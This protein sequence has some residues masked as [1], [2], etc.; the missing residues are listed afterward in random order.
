MQ[1]FK[2]NEYITLRLEDDHTVI[3]VVGEM[4][5]Q[6]KF[7][8]LNVPVDK[9]SSFDE[10]KSI[11]EA[12]EK[13]NGSMEASRSEFEI[14]SEVEFWGHCSN[15]QVW[16]ESSYNT[17]LLH[18]NLAFPLLKRL[19]QKGD[20]LAKKILSSE[21]AE[22]FSTGY[23]PVMTYLSEEGFLH[24]LNKEELK[25]LIKG[26]SPLVLLESTSKICR[27]ALKILVLKDISL[28][29][30]RFSLNI[31]PNFPDEFRRPFWFY[32]LTKSLKV[33][34]VISLGAYYP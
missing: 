30:G 24:F 7:L 11:D 27:L 33:N 1:E 9:I 22:R 17:N 32:D 12:A 14:P 21:I 16:V 23:I 34:D 6:C 8:L 3:Y 13:L 20:H 31:T 25:T 29:K 28:I 2:V 18:R 26:F 4:F 10:I 19:A 15:I 5:Q